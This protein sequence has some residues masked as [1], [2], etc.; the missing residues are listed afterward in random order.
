MNKV[1]LSDRA[2]VCLDRFHD[3]LGRHSAENAVRAQVQDQYH[4]F[5]S[6]TD[7]IG[8]F[9]ATD[10]SLEYRL[11]NAPELRGIFLQL[12]LATESSIHRSKPSAAHQTV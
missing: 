1:A 10:A 4:R 9:A 3:F 11:V 7:N 2:Q 8:V 12:L 5:N 6:W